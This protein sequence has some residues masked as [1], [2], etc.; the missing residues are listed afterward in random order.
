MLLCAGRAALQQYAHVK[1]KKTP[2][3]ATLYVDN[4]L[5]ECRCPRPWM[6]HLLLVLSCG[7]QAAAEAQP[8]RSKLTTY[9]RRRV[10][11]MHEVWRYCGWYGWRL[12]DFTAT[13]RPVETRASQLPFPSVSMFDLLLFLLTLHVHTAVVLSD[14]LMLYH[15]EQHDERL[16]F[17]PKYHACS[18]RAV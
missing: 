9:E 10:E 16:Q 8:R 12:I 1:Q 17:L 6:H 18:F 15:V 7:L 4:L 2:A 14:A 3:L 11:D 13:E 5:P